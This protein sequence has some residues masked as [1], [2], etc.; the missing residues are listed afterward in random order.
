MFMVNDPDWAPIFAPGGALAREGD[1]ISREVY[2]KT[3][4]TIARDGP[5]AFY[6]VSPSILTAIA[7]AFTPPLGTHC[8][9]PRRQD[10]SDWWHHNDEGL[11]IIQRR[12]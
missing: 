9:I 3:L 12:H 11:D 8:R 6:Y 7:T 10:T 1:Y 4:E 2:S 5:D